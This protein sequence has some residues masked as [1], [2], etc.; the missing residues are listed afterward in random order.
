MASPSI[1]GRPGAYQDLLL[2]V[3]PPRVPRNLVARQRLTIATDPLR[4]AGILLVQAPAG[5]GKTSLLAQWRKEIQAAGS[6]VAWVSSHTRDDPHRWVQ[7]LVLAVRV[8]SGRANFGRAAFEFD[9]DDP[10]DHVTVLLAELAQAAQDVVL[11]IDEAERLPPASRETLVYLLR[12]APSN[13]RTIIG[14]RPEW[15]AELDELVA[16]GQCVV[17]GPGLLR[18]DLDE[19]LQLVQ[20]RAGSRVD[21]TAAARLH[22]LTEGWPLGVQMALSILSRSGDASGGMT[23]MALLGGGLQGQLVTLLLTNLV[24]QDR[25]FLIQLAILGHLHPDLCRVVT[26]DAEAATR[27]AR[28]SM[29]TPVFVSAEGG[30]WLRMHALVRDALREQFDR[31]TVH[32]RVQAH[33]R[34]AGWLAEHG[35]LD[36]AARHALTAGQHQT[37]Y[38]LAERSLYES[39]MQRGRQNAVLAWLEQMPAQELDR[40]PRLLLAMAWTLASSERHAEAERFVVRILALPDVSEGIRCECALILSGAAVFADDPDRFADLHAPWAEAVPTTDA[41]LVQVHA[42]RMAYRALLDGEPAQAR[43]FLQQMPQGEHGGGHAYIGRWSQLIAG[44]SYVGEGQVHQA[45][46]VLKPALASAEAELGRRNRFSCML[47]ALMAVAAWESDRPDEAAALLADRLDIIEHS[48]LPEALL[49]AYRTA[50]RVAAAEGTE[51]RAL[52]LLGG[53]AA[54]AAARGRPRRRVAS[55]GDQVR[56][57]ARAYRAQTCRHLCAQ[58][59]ALIEAEI[60]PDGARRDRGPMWRRSVEALR[61]QALGYAAIAAKDWQAARAPL[62]RA[63]EY[64]RQVKFGRLHIE[65]LGLRAFALARCG[66]DAEHM[67]REAVNLASAYGLRRVLSDAHP[68]LGTWMATLSEEGTQHPVSLHAELAPVRA[69]PA[70]S[71]QQGGVLTPKESEVLALLAR[72]LSNK[73]IGRAM[74]VSETTVKWHVKNLFFKLDAGTRKQVVQRARILG[75]IDFSI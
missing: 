21:R 59:D 39:L 41:L 27:L 58:I 20:A 70:V 5:F 2:K 56:R 61:D 32:Q 9:G 17:I 67:V 51:H 13:L 11:I 6:A 30:T 25:D 14:A 36:D 28:L 43:R 12:H 57:H 72:N 75:L 53:L 19:T 73:E 49:L 29:D 46:Q 47:A 42:N 52:E 65:L 60:K 69:A 62:A 55:L 38:D 18:F 23:D 66:Q 37:A 34:A 74:D 8:A 7:S 68:D 26:G 33:A 3:T 63:D 50:A 48:G 15:R 44:L 40:R 35:F 24:P 71:A 4:D 31:L 64:A 10:L 45:T 54:A 22:A 16:Y 1:T